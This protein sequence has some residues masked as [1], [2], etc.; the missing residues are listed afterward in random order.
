MCS[1][2]LEWTPCN[3]RESQP[4]CVF[5]SYHSKTI[6]LA[7]YLGC[8]RQN[9]GPAFL[10]SRVMGR[11]V[12]V[13]KCCINRTE[14]SGK[15]VTPVA[16]LDD[17]NVEEGK[18]LQSRDHPIPRAAPRTEGD[19][20][21]SFDPESTLNFY[22]GEAVMET[23]LPEDALHRS[24][25]ARYAQFGLDAYNVVGHIAGNNVR[26]LEAVRAVCVG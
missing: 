19:E 24:I 12:Q 20:A 25:I 18:E 13:V 4:F 1:R 7:A 6:Y 11:I 21:P 16:V 26:I 17:G 2:A 22:H 8:N 5:F 9:R 10:R 3:E 23:Q 14:N 15:C